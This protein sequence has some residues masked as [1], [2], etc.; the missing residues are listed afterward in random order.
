MESSDTTMYQLSL[1]TVS[2]ARKQHCSAKV[3]VLGNGRV[4]KNYPIQLDLVSGVLS[5]AAI[6]IIANIWV[7]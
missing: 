3:S 2:I 7:K 1:C 5:C 4:I 6:I